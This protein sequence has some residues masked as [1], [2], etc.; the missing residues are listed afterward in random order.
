MFQLSS[1]LARNVRAFLFLAAAFVS[2]A[3]HADYVYGPPYSYNTAWGSGDSFLSVDAAVNDLIAHYES[4][5]NSGV[6]TCLPHT[7]ST[8][9]GNSGTAATVTQSWVNQDGTTG[10]DIFAYIWATDVTGSGFQPKNAGGCATMCTGGNGSAQDS[11]GPPGSSGNGTT[12]D[13][14][15][16]VG[17]SLEGDPINAANGNE[18]R[19]ETD[20]PSSRWLTFRR[21]YNSSSYVATANM[22]LKWRHSFD[23]TLALMPGSG[24]NS[25]LIYATRPDGSLVRFRST[26][27]VWKADADQAE[28]LTTTVDPATGKFSAY[29]MRV[30]ATQETE[31]YDASGRLLSI[32][33]DNGWVTT[34]TYSDASTPASIA[35]KPGLPITVTDP[36]GRTLS[37]RYDTNGRLS[38]V[39]D[40]QGQQ[41]S[42]AYNANGVLAQ[43]TYPG[44]TSVQYLYAEA[45]YAPAGSSYPGELTGV[46]DEKGTRYETVTFSSSN[47][48][49]SSQFAGGAGKITLSPAGYYQNGGIPSSVV[50]PLGANL[51]LYYS[52]DGAETLKPGGVSAS[53]G[54][55]CSQRMQSIAYANGYPTSSTDLN[56]VIT[57]TTYDTNG[58]LTQEVDAS[59]T[60]IQRTINTTWDVAHR[61]P[62]TRT[63]LD[64]AGNPVAKQAWAYNA[65]GQETAQCAVDP[66]M[67]GTYACGSQANAPVGVRQ[68]RS[69]YCD[70]VDATQCPSV[71]LL[72]TVDGPRTDVSD[73]TYYRYYLTTDESGCATVGGTCHRASDVADMTNAAGH[74]TSVLAYDRH[75]RPVRQKDANGTITDIT[76]TPRGWLATRTV[77]ANPDG[78]A[79]NADATTT[80]T[81]EATGALKTVTDPDGVTQTLTYDGA[82]RLVDVADAQG[83]HVH[84][85]LD[86]SGNRI[87][88]ETF[89]TGG[90]SR[91]SLVRKYDTLGRLVAV[92]DGLGHLVFD[93]TASGSY[94]GNG[95][96]LSKKDARGFARKDTFDAMN[97]LVSSVANANG[98]D[99]ATK[100]TTTSFT[101][102]ALDQLRS[103]TD[104]DGLVT[105]YAFDGLSNATSQTSPDTG[106]QSAGFDAEG[107][108]VTQTDGKGTIRTRTVDAAGRPTSIAYTDSKLDIAFHYDESNLLTGCPASLGTGHLTRVVEA[109]VTTAYCYDN[110]GRIIEQRQ[111][112]GAVTDVT[113]YVY[114]K[115]GRRAATISPGGTVTEYGRNAL[116]Q[117]TSVQ[118]TPAGGASQSIV[119]SAT[120]LPFGPVATYTLGSGQVVIRTHDANYQVTD[121]TSP[122]LNLHFARD[123]AGYITALGDASGA[124]PATEQYVYDPLYRLTSVNDASGQA[125]EAYVYSKAGDRLSKTAPGLATGAYGYQVGS[126]WLTSVGVGSRAYD[127]NG[128]TTGSALAG[129]SWGYGYNG[130]GQLTVI[131]QGGATVATYAYNALDQRIGKTVGGVVQRFAYGPSGELLGEYGSTSRDYVWLDGLPVGVVDIGTAGATVGYVH[132]D[133]L[134]TPRAV[135]GSAGT[136]LWNWQFKANPFGEMVP[137]STNGFSLNLRY[138]GQY[139]DTES[140]LVYNHHRFYEPATGRYIQSDPVGLAAGPSTYAYVSGAPLSSVDPQGLDA[141]MFVNTRTV[142]LMFGKNAGHSAVAIGND[143]TGWT[144]YQEGGLDPAGNQ[145]TTN[146]KFPTLSLLEGEVSEYKNGIGAPMSISSAYDLQEGIH[147]APLQDMLMNTWAQAHLRDPYR[148]ST[149]NCGDFVLGV[150]RAGGLHPTAN[151]VGP[152][153]PN[154][155][156]IGASDDPGRFDPRG[157]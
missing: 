66:A 62:L 151:S 12:K 52:D 141:V 24:A 31:A 49:L 124:T 137:T 38:A 157:R 75:G 155:M 115:A 7:F 101:F 21:F 64:A 92:T 70:A 136:T 96:L 84:Y 82:H 46:V 73:I 17:T 103:A 14:F 97:R 83:G 153:V 119:S 76:Y 145:L 135:T 132:A 102:D 58:L 99:A 22:G 107:N 91:R 89:D 139:F 93:A 111:T 27:G 40:A 87:R 34:L 13:P 67:S 154:W 18:Y 65:R 42:Y 95:N 143:E 80:L 140:G 37:L 113:D 3:A 19:Q 112:Q 108:V 127:A 144:F 138:P 120:Y 43:V 63:I 15:A 142:P 41:V 29:S 78:S 68:V 152:T 104:P 57:K 126:H 9:Y 44:G 32:T 110:Q 116:G 71:G 60:A 10:S 23:R 105:T 123:Q 56:G 134:G 2:V 5:C 86:P 88:E 85:T 100:A 150:L 79:S 16:N 54:N 30:A 61:A 117:I 125:V 72:L 33:D 48:A 50:T 98:T 122:A 4:D 121:V 118:V 35:P 20:L 148:G 26:N 1:L 106:S 39:T 149:N 28:T 90:T 156:S 133:A 94:D 6:L 131:Q 130:R 53:C 77:R 114:T 55:Q 147:T 25:G 74:V 59:G 109:S 45:A 11:L 36:Q 47:R 69:T 128:S 81:Y 129:T 8:A 51:T 146:W